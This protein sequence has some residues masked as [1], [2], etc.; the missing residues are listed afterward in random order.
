MT[1]ST[2]WL[3]ASSRTISSAWSK[4][5]RRAITRAPCISAWASLPIAIFPSGTITAPRRPARA[6]YAAALAAV[7]PVEAQMIASAPDP[8]ARDTATVI[9]RSLKLPVGFAPS[10]LR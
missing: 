3:L 1:S 9:P 5:P 8:F 2:G 4:L 7:F 10:S 6:A